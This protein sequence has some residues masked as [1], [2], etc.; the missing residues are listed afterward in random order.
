VTRARAL[1]LTA[2]ARGFVFAFAGAAGII[3]L[4]VAGFVFWKTFAS[5]LDQMLASLP[6]EF[7]SL[8]GGMEQ[9]FTSLMGYLGILYQHPIPFALLAIGAIG[10]A[11]RAIAAEVESGTAD[12]LFAR[13]V[14][15]GEVLAY[16]VGGALLRIAVLAAAFP[17]GVALGA[18]V[19]AQWDLV[20]FSR[21][22]GAALNAF[23]LFACVFG[24]ALVVS[25]LAR[26]A[27]T[28]YA[29]AG[30]ATVVFYL[31][32]YIA[33][34]KESWGALN[35]ITPFGLFRPGE[36]MN[37]ARA[38]WGDSAALLALAFL[39]IGAA[40]VILRRRDL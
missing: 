30:G 27:G 2:A 15:R 39:C 1:L 3:V 18:T 6:E 11:A 5:S 33:M 26:T 13:P 37:G 25:A 28:V 10:S 14:A 38:P 29:W 20:V 19:T 8:F 22:A 12:L 23:A 16:H 9:Q 17:A 34:V 36:L 21:C 40:W 7:R 35:E 4:V 24:Y 32:S 31:F